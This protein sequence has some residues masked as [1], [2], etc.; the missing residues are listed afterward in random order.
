[1]PRHTRADTTE[2]AAEV[3]AEAEE[4]H[5]P[6]SEREWIEI[7][8]DFELTCDLAHVFQLPESKSPPGNLVTSTSVTVATK[9]GATFSEGAFR[10][11]AKEGRV[12]IPS[13]H[14]VKGD[15]GRES[16]VLR[17]EEEMLAGTCVIAMPL[18]LKTRNF[19]KE[20]ESNFLA[21]GPG[22]RYVSKHPALDIKHLDGF[23]KSY[24]FFSELNLSTSADVQ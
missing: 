14:L 9:K 12:C 17:G 15:D 8:S 16:L 21:V 19:K 4:A 6:D 3:T 22:L 24:D 2:Q 11:T 13:L 20:V 23:V 1:M 10:L 5:D 18:P 7:P